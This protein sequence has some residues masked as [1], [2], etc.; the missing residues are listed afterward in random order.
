V[1]Q[2]KYLTPIRDYWYYERHINLKILRY[3]LRRG[4]KINRRLRVSTGHKDLASAMIE[5]SKIHLEVEAAI[6]VAKN[7]VPRRQVFD[8][9]TDDIING[10]VTDPN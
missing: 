8:M 2:T 7:G 10:L 9:P 3:F 4:E 1:R 6:S 5:Y